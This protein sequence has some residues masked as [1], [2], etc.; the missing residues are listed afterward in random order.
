MDEAKLFSVMCGNR[1]R[2]NG[3]KLKHRKFC[4]NMWKSF[5]T[6]RVYGVYTVY[7]DF[8]DLSGRLPVQHIIEYLF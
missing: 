3:L 5:F 6:I 1:T 8:Q 2:C 4:T 7:G